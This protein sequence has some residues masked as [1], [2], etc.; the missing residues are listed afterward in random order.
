MRQAFAHDADLVMVPDGDTGAP[1]AAITVAL[2]GHWEHQPPC[3]L[4]PHHSRADREGDTV[5][6]RTLFVTE[7]EQADGVHRLIDEALRGGELCGPDGVTTRWELRTTEAADVAQHELN[8]ARR[9]LQ[10]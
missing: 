10:S 4:A 3:P 6:V 9:L 7:P 8:H 5:H 1:G 2:C